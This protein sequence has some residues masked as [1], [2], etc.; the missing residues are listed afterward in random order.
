M[1]GGA[2]G[3]SCNL[4]QMQFNTILLL[5]VKFQPEQWINIINKVTNNTF[6]ILLFLL[7][8]SETTLFLTTTR[9]QKSLLWF[10]SVMD[11][12]CSY[13]QVSLKKPSPTGTNSWPPFQKCMELTCV[14]TLPAPFQA[15]RQFSSSH[16]A[17]RQKVWIDF[18]HNFEERFGSLL[19]NKA[20]VQRI[21]FRLQM[22]FRV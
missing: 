7:I 17:Q 12:K 20:K 15:C 2:S 1:L 19:P 21:D 11:R 13:R 22:G 3:N 18:G 4:M 14:Q 10:W 16:S 9:E 6:F 5:E 8:K